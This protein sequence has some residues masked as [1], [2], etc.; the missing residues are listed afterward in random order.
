MSSIWHD[1]ALKAIESNLLG[2]RFVEV[3]HKLPWG[4]DEINRRAV[5]ADEFVTTEQG[6]CDTCILHI[7]AGEGVEI[8]LIKEVV[9]KALDVSTRI[10]ILE[11]NPYLGYWRNVFVNLNRLKIVENAIEDKGYKFTRKAIDKRNLFYSVTAIKGMDLSFGRVTNNNL[12]KL[13]SYQY[14]DGLP[15]KDRNIFCLSSEKQKDSDRILSEDTAMFVDSLDDSVGFYSVVGGMMFLNILAELNVQRKMVLFDISLP[16][17]LFAILIIELIRT[18]RTIEE[19]DSAVNQDSVTID[20]MKTFCKIEQLLVWMFSSRGNLPRPDKMMV[21]ANIIKSGHWRNQYDKVRE[22]VLQNKVRYHFGGFPEIAI[23]DG[24]I[25][26]TSTVNPESYKDYGN[27][28]I[29]EAYSQRDVPEL[30]KL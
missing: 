13:L 11:H 12:G 30:V 5:K 7:L 15:E 10:L 18:N 28:N 19:F 24:S 22:Y 26:Y 14:K 1:N 9:K 17:V 6:E 27:C 23:P 3:V 2:K 21:W 25:I 8:E 20:K 4:F 16:Q 29:I